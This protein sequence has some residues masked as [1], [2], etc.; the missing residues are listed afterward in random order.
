[1]TA[2]SQKQDL[3][4]FSNLIF[5]LIIEKFHKMYPITLTSWSSQVYLPPLQYPPPKEERG[6]GKKEEEEEEEKKY[7]ESIVL[8]FKK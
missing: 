7:I 8:F 1:M 5:L 6:G 4:I 2:G 3:F